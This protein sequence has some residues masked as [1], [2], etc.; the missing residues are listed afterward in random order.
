MDLTE[1]GLANRRDLGDHVWRFDLRTADLRRHEQDH[2][3][4]SCT[5]CGSLECLPREAVHLSAALSGSAY[6]RSAEIQLRGRCARC[7]A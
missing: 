3:H 1:R 4:F 6:G 7:A 5:E 2:P